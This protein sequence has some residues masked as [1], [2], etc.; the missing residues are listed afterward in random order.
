MEEGERSRGSAGAT[1]DIGEE[2]E[3][4]EPPSSQ[5]RDPPGF[6][7]GC[8]LRRRDPK[9]GGGRSRGEGPFRGE[10]EVEA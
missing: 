10:G 5:R 8:A 9:G 7:R 2:A 6:A 3:E 1:V 4:G